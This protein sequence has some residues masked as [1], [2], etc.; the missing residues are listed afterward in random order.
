MHRIEN[1]QIPTRNRIRREDLDTRS[2]ER[3]VSP[4]V[5]RVVDFDD[6][7]PGAVDECETELLRGVLRLVVDCAG[8]VDVKA[9][10]EVPVVQAI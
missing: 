7:V 5:C 1:H 4:A 3:R 6:E 8:V 9:G 2:E 10:V